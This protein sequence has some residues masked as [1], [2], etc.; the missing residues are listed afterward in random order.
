MLQKILLNK[1]INNFCLF[2]IHVSS[3]RSLSGVREQKFGKEKKGS[4]AEK[5]KAYKA[6]REGARDWTYCSWAQKAEGAEGED[7]LR[8]RAQTESM[9]VQPKKKR[10][11]QKAKTLRTVKKRHRPTLG[12]G[13][14][15]TFGSPGKLRGPGSIQIQP[16]DIR[17][18]HGVPQIQTVERRK[19]PTCWE[20]GTSL[21]VGSNV[22]C[23]KKHL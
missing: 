3:R 16:E 13:R 14:K 1:E 6:R 20:F 23:R 10:E 17:R 15:H 7:P 9:Q 12:R 21:W 11:R 19:Q 8:K 2:I 18:V 22:E 5:A 4:E